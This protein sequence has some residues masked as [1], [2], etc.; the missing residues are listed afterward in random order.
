MNYKLTPAETK[1]VYK[2]LQ[3]MW[4]PRDDYDAMRS[5]MT[6]IRIATESNPPQGVACK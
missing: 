1:A 4:I 6:K 3:Q 5:A 2:A